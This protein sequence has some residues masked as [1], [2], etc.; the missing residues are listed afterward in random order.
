[1]TSQTSPEINNEQ[2]TKTTTSFSSLLNNAST[3]S[4][5]HTPAVNNDF[6][7]QT[8]SHDDDDEVLVAEAK[9]KRRRR[10]QRQKKVKVTIVGSSSSDRSIQAVLERNS[11]TGMFTCPACHLQFENPASIQTHTSKTCSQRNAY[12]ATRQE[13]Q[14]SES[15]ESTAPNNEDESSIPSREEEGGS[16]LPSSAVA[17][18]SSSDNALP[19][20]SSLGQDD[21]VVLRILI[22]SHLKWIRFYQ[23]LYTYPSSTSSS[24]GSSE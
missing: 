18:L 9:L 15:N 11:S 19:T 10:R 22:F 23:I 21:L 20:A 13:A 16:Q 6:A 3:D 17:M 1:M 5:S 2:P 12:M 8:P 4:H 7:N 24:T 14:A